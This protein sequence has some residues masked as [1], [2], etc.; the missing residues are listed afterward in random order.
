MSAPRALFGDDDGLMKEVTLALTSL[1]MCACASS[2]PVRYFVLDP[3]APASEAPRASGEPL[4]IVSVRLPP[5]LDRL[6]IVRENTANKLTVSNQDRWGAPLQDMTQR[7]LSQDLMLRLAPGR[8]VLPGQP[9]T[10]GTAAISVDVIEFGVDASGTIVLDGS[11][12]IVPRGSDVAVASYRFELSERVVRGDS[13]EQAHV[14][15]LLLGQLAD[16]IA[17]K[18][19]DSRN[20]RSERG[21]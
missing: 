1:L 2:P 16:S 10:A 21:H 4:Q 19:S 7:V 15:S 3:V 11:W 13:A 17:T 20:G 8:V 6:Q 9:A 12:S 18:A 14:M 5:T